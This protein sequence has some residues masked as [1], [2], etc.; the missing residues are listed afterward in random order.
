MVL[1]KYLDFC[2]ILFPDYNVLYVKMKTPK[3]ATMKKMS[4]LLLL[5]SMLLVII[6]GCTEDYQDSAGKEEKTD[7]PVADHLPVILDTHLEFLTSSLAIVGF[8]ISD[9]GGGPIINHGVCW[10]TARY[11][12]T[13]NFKVTG[14]GEY[15]KNIGYQIVGLKSNTKYYLRA[16]AA[17]NLGTAY[18]EQVSLTTPDLEYGPLTDVD[19]NFYR[20][21]Q[22]GTQIWMAENLKTTRYNDGVAIPFVSSD[23]VWVG[24]KIGGYR[25]YDNNVF[26][27]RDL[28]GA[29]YNWYA[30]NT[31]RLCPLGWHVPS[32]KEWMQLEITLGM[33]VNDANSWGNEEFPMLFSRGTDQGAQ[34]KASSGWEDLDG[35]E[36][37]GTNTSG[38]S[39]LPGGDTGWYGK[40]ELAGICGNWWSSTELNF[41][42]GPDTESG[43]GRTLC[44]G[45]GGVIR[46]AYY[47]HIGFSVRCVKNN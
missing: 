8:N 28:Y 22:I 42:G 36:G 14:D 9:D 2:S 23:P 43:I 34:M 35:R 11:P 1:S 47:K 32:D 20:T 33:A 27:Y 4:V 46:A 44:S 37:N 16:F 18:G 7:Y 26:I 10:D 6:C 30:V 45:D 21:I 41:G 15:S 3:P 31:K 29:L 24:M 12:T 39:G 13:E 38:F 17:N 40:F 19:G 25:W 5:I